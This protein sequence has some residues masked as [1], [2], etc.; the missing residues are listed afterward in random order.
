MLLLSPRVQRLLT[1]LAPEEAYSFRSKVLDIEHLLLA[2]LKSADGLGYI[3]LKAMKINVLMLQTT[4]EQSLPSRQQSLE[5]TEIPHSNRLRN[6]LDAAAVEARILRCDYI[7]TEHL[8]LAALREEKSVIQN[9]F[10]KARISLDQARQF[11]AEVEKKVPSSAKLTSNMEPVFASNSFDSAASRRNKTQGGILQQ[12]CRD[13]TEAARNDETDTVV[14]RDAEIARVIQTLSRRTK[15]N[16]VLVGEPGVGKTAVVEGLAQHIAA[17]DVPRELLK[18]RILLLDLSGMIAGTKYRGEFEERMKRMLKEV[19]ENPDVILFIDE[20]HTI[21]GA[22]GPEGTM[23][24]SNMMKPALSRGDIQ[25]IGATTTKEYRNRLERDAA[26]TRRFQM[27]R[28]EEPSDADTIEMLRGLKYRYESFHHVYYEDEA[29]ESI[30]KCSRRYI[31]D[32]CLP[33]KAFDI[34]DEAGAAKKINSEVRPPELDEIERTIDSLLAEKRSLVENQDYERAAMVRDK[35]QE[36]RHR[37]DEINLSLKGKDGADRTHVTVDDVLA[38]I[39]GMTGIPAERLDNGEAKKLL[40]MEKVLSEEVVG[41]T[42]AVKAICSAVKRHRAGVSSQKRPVGSFF[43]LGPTGVGKTQLAKSLA[44]FLFG[45]EDALLRF[46]MSEYS[47]RS[48]ATGLTGTSPGYIGYEDGGKL[49]KKVLEHPYSVVLFDEIE[50]A[51]PNIYN[52]MLQ[53]LEEGELTDGQGRTVNFRNTVVIFTS[54]AGSNRITSDG[55]LGF[56]TAAEGLLPYEEMKASAMEELKRILSPELLNRIDDVVVFH[57][58]DRDVL[59][60]IVDLQVAELASRISD[61]GLSVVLKPKARQF[62]I[63]NGYEPSMGARP[64]RRLI[65]HDVEDALANLLLS[66]KRGDSEQVVIDSDGKE[67]KLSFKKSR[68]AS[69]VAEIGSDSEKEEKILIEEKI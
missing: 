57:A 33:D 14:G 19:K 42:E 46:N 23:E 29:I 4:I 5:L 48:S 38:V 15:N 47:E 37:L 31:T 45:T 66:G 50:K 55:R 6:L 2:L 59:S 54:N 63:E 10:I 13:L 20:I 8:L 35:V 24:A 40:D 52:L 21:I 36:L 41:Q 34:L 49:T 39:S 16:P 26:L 53:I 28:V 1:V 64:M 18:K 25:V 17:G 43:F 62:M 56:S 68:R 69:H 44:K 9:F 30:V 22:G 32:R 60:K 51:D 7:G 58:L 67:L 27:I 3:A 11:V 65:Q 61:Q 12:F